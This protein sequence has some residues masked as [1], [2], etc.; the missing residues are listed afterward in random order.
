[1]YYTSRTALTLYLTF[2]KK[3]YDISEEELFAEEQ[4]TMSLKQYIFQNQMKKD[5]E[6]DLAAKGWRTED[7]QR[8][9]SEVKNLPQTKLTRYIY[10]RLSNNHHEEDIVQDLIR[11][12]WKEEQIRKEIERF[13]VI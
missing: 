5:L 10:Q 12:G 1:M 13:N 9:I 3:Y 2:K 6:Y 4:D 8:I 11:A 7:V